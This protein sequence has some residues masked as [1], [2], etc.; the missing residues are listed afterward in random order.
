[1]ITSP[2]ATKCLKHNQVCT[3]FCSWCARPIC[4]DCVA[5][6]GGKK[7]CDKCHSKK[8]A[9]QPAGSPPT[10]NAPKEPIKN[11]DPSLSDEFIKAQRAM[12]EE[13]SKFRKVGKF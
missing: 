13:P 3:T 11:N 8:M 1:M 12:H 4:D 7:Y 6:A 9:S 2:G 5:Y 10:G